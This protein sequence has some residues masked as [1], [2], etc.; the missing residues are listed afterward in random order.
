M[1]GILLW[2]ELPGRR[3]RLKEVHVSVKEETV[4]G[5]S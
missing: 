1:M 2:M 5:E 4:C 3:K